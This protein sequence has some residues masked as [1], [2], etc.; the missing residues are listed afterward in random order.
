MLGIY[1][2]DC[3]HSLQVARL[4]AQ[5]FDQLCPL[6]H[7]GREER[8]LLEAAAQLHDTGFLVSHSQHHKHSYYLIRNSELLGFTEDEKELIANIARYH[9]KSFPEMKHQQ[10]AALSKKDQRTVRILAAILRVADGLEPYRY[11]LISR[12]SR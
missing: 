5:L 11:R 4:A 10:F 7:L 6:H 2:A 9:R 1:N 12:R 8:S 3:G